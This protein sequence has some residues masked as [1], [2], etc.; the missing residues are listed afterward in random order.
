MGSR[1]PR[2]LSER[3]P[4]RTGPGLVREHFIASACRSTVSR[5]G[6]R[7]VWTVVAMLENQPT[8]PAPSL[9]PCFDRPLD[10]RSIDLTALGFA[11]ISGGGWNA[12]RLRH[13]YIINDTFGSDSTRL[14][15]VLDRYWT[16]S[17]PLLQL[18]EVQSV[19]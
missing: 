13:R 3:E 8:F 16:P 17:R 9:E 1:R 5:L 11:P 10:G 12:T 2:S 19:I 14:V 6:S 4:H 15:L 18:T 7:P